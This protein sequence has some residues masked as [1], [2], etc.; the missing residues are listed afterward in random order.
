M[1]LVVINIVDSL[2]KINF[3]IWNAAISTAPQLFH[4]H[5]ITSELWYPASTAS[6]VLELPAE[7]KSVAL[8]STKPGLLQQ[9]LI[10]YT[11]A[12][13]LIITHG[14]WQ[15]ATKWGRLAQ[16]QGFRW[17]YVPH[18]MLEPWSMAQKA[19]K[20]KLYYQLIEG[21][22]AR[23]ANAV[24][25]VGAPERDNLANHF[26]NVVLIQNGFQ[27]LAAHP[28]PAIKNVLFLGRLHAKKQPALLAQAWL[29]SIL[30]QRSDFKL[31]LAGPDEGEAQRIQALLLNNPSVTNILLKEPVYGGDKEDLLANAAFFTLPSLSEGFPTSVVEAMGAGCIPII[32][33]GCNFPDAFEHNLAINSG[34]NLSSIAAALNQLI[35]ID[36]ERLHIWHNKARQ[37]AV[38]AFS[39][40]AIAR[41][42]AFWYKQLLTPTHTQ[43]ELTHI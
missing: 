29:Q 36:A 9:K 42:Q 41:H 34:T 5:G 2:A 16:K 17:I 37:Y 14:S 1:S 11:P 4:N 15:F 3:G 8:E 35:E 32:S 10:G 33:D 21:P 30:C 6:S 43:H 25:A 27:P 22:A 13:T 38:S 7:A 28:K 19:W 26:E 23:H 40:D 18:G 20:K 12:A 24:R 31:I 39:L